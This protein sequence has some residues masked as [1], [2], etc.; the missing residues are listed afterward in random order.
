MDVCGVTAFRFVSDSYRYVDIQHTR[1]NPKVVF[2]E[3]LPKESDSDGLISDCI[4]TIGSE[5]L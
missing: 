1:L 5:N 4:I 3:Q 2:V